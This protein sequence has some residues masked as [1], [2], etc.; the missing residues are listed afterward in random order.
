M[1]RVIFV[2][3]FSVPLSIIVFF[4]GLVAKGWKIGLISALVTISIFLV[5]SLLS[6]L[7]QK[8]IC[9]LEENFIFI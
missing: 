2:M 8:K 6:I 4:I 1:G 5:I 7:F 3:F 9:L